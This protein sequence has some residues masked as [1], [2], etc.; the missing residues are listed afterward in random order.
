MRKASRTKKLSRQKPL[1]ENN[2]DL[3]HT[4]RGHVLKKTTNTPHFLLY[5]V[6]NTRAH[7]QIIFQRYAEKSAHVCS[8]TDASLKHI[9]DHAKLLASQISDERVYLSENISVI[10]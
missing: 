1:S 8:G 6:T 2:N 5:C 4:T 10:I 9:S 3:I 7:F